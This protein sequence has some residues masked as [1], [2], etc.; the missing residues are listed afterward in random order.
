M[1]ADLAS[2]DLPHL[3]RTDG[4]KVIV[5]TNIAETSL[6]VDGILYVVDSG[7]YKL[8]VY[9][10]KV[11][12]DALQITPISQA[13]QTKETGRAGRTGSGFCYRLYTE[14]AYRNELFENTIP[15]IPAYESGKH[16]PP[17]QV[18]GCEEPPRLWV[19]AALDNNGDLTPVGRKILPMFCGDVDNRGNVVRPE[20]ILQ[21][22]GRME[23]AD[24][25]REKFN[26]PESDHLTLLNVFNQWKSHG[27]RDDWGYET[28]PAPQAASQAR[29]VRS[30]L[31]D[32]MKKAIAAGYFHQAAR[33]KGIGEFVNIRTGLSNPFASY[34]CP[35]WTW[36]HAIPNLGPAFYSVKEKNFDG[37]TE[38]PRV[39]REFSKQKEMENEMARQREEGGEKGGFT[40]WNRGQQA[41]KSLFLAHLGMPVLVQALA[42]CASNASTTRRNLD[43]F[44]EPA[45]RFNF[46]KHIV[47][48]EMMFVLSK[49]EIET[50]F[51]DVDR[52]SS[53]R[54]SSKDV[55]ES[56]KWSLLDP[57]YVLSSHLSLV[58][59]PPAA[60][61]LCLNRL[62]HRDMQKTESTAAKQQ[63]LSASSSIVCA[64]DTRRRAYHGDPLVP[65]GG[66]GGP[67][68]GH[69]QDPNYK[70]PPS[71]LLHG[72]FGRDSIAT[73]SSY[74]RD[75]YL[76]P[77]S[78]R[79][80]SYNSATGS[81]AVFHDRYYNADSTL[82]PLPPYSYP[83]NGQD[84]NED[85]GYNY[86][87]AYET[88]NCQTVDNDAPS[89]YHQQQRYGTT[90]TTNTTP[91]A[92]QLDES[93]QAAYQEA[94]PMPKQSA[95]RAKITAPGSGNFQ[96]RCIAVRSR[97]HI[98]K[99][100]IHG[101]PPP[102][103]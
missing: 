90:A 52:L 34:E 37:R 95:G 48:M 69:V 45:L 77:S 83:G 63:R 62:L 73:T 32:I 85:G 15:E 75:S 18:T 40:Q 96:D 11:G 19:L 67:F 72:H 87:D 13:M 28:L 51:S 59:L 84:D 60:F 74:D 36:I 9:N 31:E 58:P 43:E 89:K 66:G 44:V 76:R 100:Q 92:M 70:P 20:C 68:R 23:E 55:A 102:V 27:F 7:Y 25:A 42:V 71:P 4:R 16:S 53:T 61:A 88:D 82:V 10:P 93:Q 26:V 24:A 97:N 49:E 98:R 29:E 22:K 33:V 38:T 8:K 17:P 101:P 5:A 65:P 39:S 91:G 21:A 86:E 14:M 54:K 47:S 57:N 99:P 6:T 94:E 64:P 1:P 80:D 56:V 2:Q 78:R 79:I 30:Q 35:L 103:S 81:A 50:L 41:K 46:V 3:P 12:M